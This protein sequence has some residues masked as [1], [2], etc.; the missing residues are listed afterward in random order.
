MLRPGRVADMTETGPQASTS[1]F[2][3]P[4]HDWSEP[5]SLEAH[6]SA[7]VAALSVRTIGAE[8][9]RASD[10]LDRALVDDLHA[11]FDLPRFDNS[12][13]DGFALDA[14]STP[15]SFDVGAM[16]PAG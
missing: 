12:Q 5:R 1:S 8:T 9:V 13:M 6:V 3:G 4:F 11:P 2:R 15:G 10:A 14:T 16:I 7:L